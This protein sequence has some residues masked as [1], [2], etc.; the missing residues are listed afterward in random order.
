MAAAAPGADVQANRE[1]R[2]WCQLSRAGYVLISQAFSLH[3]MPGFGASMFTFP[4]ASQVAPE[5]W[6]SPSQQ[7]SLVEALWAC[8]WQ[9]GSGHLLGTEGHSTS[10]ARG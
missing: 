1:E 10:V 2:A 9:G 4:A 3:A 5:R 8:D 6:A 7:E